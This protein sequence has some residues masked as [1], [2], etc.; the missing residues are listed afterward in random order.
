MRAFLD[1]GAEAV[2]AFEPFPKSVATLRDDFVDSPKVQIFGLAIG[3][4]DE[5]VVLHVVEDRSGCHANA[6]HSLVPFEETPTLRIVEQIPVECRTLASLVE[7]GAVPPTIGILKVDAERSDFAVLRGMGPLMCAVAMIEYWDDL[8]ETVGPAAYHLSDL[9]PF[10]VERGYTNFVVVKRH[11]QFETLHINDAKT[12]SGDWGNVIFVHDTVFPQSARRPSTPRWPPRSS[13][14]STERRF[15][16]GEA[17]RR[18]DLIEEIHEQP[19]AVAETTVESRLEML[20]EQERGLEAYLRLS[21]DGGMWRW[22]APQ[23]GVLY[24]HDPA[25]FHVPEHYL[26]LGSLPSPPLISIV[27]PTMNSEQFVTHTIDSVIDQG[28]PRLEYII[29]DGDSTDDTLQIVESY[30]S[31]I[32]HLN[33]ARDSGM[34]QAINRGFS[35]AT[36]EILAYLNSDDLLLP[37][38]LHYVASYFAAHPEVDVVYGHR[39]IINMN[40]AEIGRWVLPPHDS[41]VLSWADYV[42]QETLF[43]RRRI[44]DKVGSAMDETLPIR[45]RLGFA[46][47]VPRGRRDVHPPASLPRRVPRP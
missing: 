22:V 25:P 8:P 1:A 2:Y 27:T 44:W 41:A 29:Q 18:L 32:A 26:R 14:S 24:Q 37:G 9:A 45:L 36:G 13:V 15:F 7:E 23:L 20:A 39:V 35:H 31:K 28:Y 6:F 16:A 47:P 3:D 30:S 4:R 46:A 33:S 40:N 12:R 38:S 42:P 21:A 5:R 10:M 43:W 34:S 19:P 17:E 11:D